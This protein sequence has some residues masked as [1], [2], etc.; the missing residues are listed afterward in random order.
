MR[1]REDRVEQLVLLLYDIEGYTSYCDFHTSR[2]EFKSV[3]DLTK[4]VVNGCNGIITD[5]GGRPYNFTGDGYLSAFPQSHSEAALDAA[6]EIQRLS[7]ELKGKENFPKKDLY[8]RAALH[9]GECPLVKFDGNENYTPIGRT[10]SK[11]ER[12]EGCARPGEIFAS[13]SVIEPVKGK[14]HLEKII[15]LYLKGITNQN[16][17][18]KV[19]GKKG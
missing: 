17:I 12:I 10:P 7:K 13:E 11:L 19:H 16:L 6:L 2:R 15:G 8:L 4:M 1:I 5:F 18:Y 14:Y 9:K 3:I